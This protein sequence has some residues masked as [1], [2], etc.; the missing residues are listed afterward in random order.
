MKTD[1]FLSDRLRNILQA[2]NVPWKEKKMFGG[3]CFMVDDKMCFGT[4]KGGLM[5]RVATEEVETLSAKQATGQMTL[6]GRAMK[7]F[8]FVGPEGYDN[9]AQLD[10]WI[11]KCLQFNPLAKA[12]KKK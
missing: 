6:G 10:F 9:D 2:K 8:L 12:S 7:G 1:P 5:L 4:F 3:C 11:Q